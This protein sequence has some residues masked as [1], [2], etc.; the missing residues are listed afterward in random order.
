MVHLYRVFTMNGAGSTGSC[1]VWVSEWESGE[2]KWRPRTLLS[3]VLCYDITMAMTWLSRRIFHLHC[4]LTRPP[5]YMQPIIDWNVIQSITV[6]VTVLVFKC[7][8][9]LQI[10][11][12]GLTLRLLFLQVHSKLCPPKLLNNSTIFQLFEIVSFH[13]LSSHMYKGQCGGSILLQRYNC[14]FLL[15][16][17]AQQSTHHP[18]VRQTITSKQCS[19]LLQY[20]W[21]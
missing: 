17:Y 13:T 10:I 9:N 6:S 7:L 4:N 11:F 20:L 12:G 15:V 5:S 19:L 8:I 2:W 18:C 14:P 3:N 16:R 21:W 1:S